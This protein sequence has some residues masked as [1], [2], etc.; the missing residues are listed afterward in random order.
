[1]SHHK[2][3]VIDGKKCGHVRITNS[4][5]ILSVWVKTDKQQ[6]LFVPEQAFPI[7]YVRKWEDEE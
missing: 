6:M 2:E 3:I 4:G 1:M 7:D 5:I